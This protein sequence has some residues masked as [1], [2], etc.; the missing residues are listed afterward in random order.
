MLPEA[1]VVR[2]RHMLDAALEAVEFA[3]G[4]CRSDLEAN[5]M[6]ARA[7][8]RD[9]EIVGEAAS[10]VSPASRQSCPAIPWASV[11]GMR[12]RLIHGYFDIDLDRVWD[13]VVDDLPALID[14]LRRALGT[15]DEPNGQTTPGQ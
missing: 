6:L 2:L 12:N 9:I 7:L 13:T 3:S 10:Q 1:D 4:H 14:E 11:V 8:V 15:L 5:R